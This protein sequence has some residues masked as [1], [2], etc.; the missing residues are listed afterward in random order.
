MELLEADDDEFGRRC[1]LMRDKDGRAMLNE[2]AGQLQ[3]LS[4]HI[5][6]VADGGR[7]ARMRHQIFED[8][9]MPEKHMA[10]AA[11]IVRLR[12]QDCR[13]GR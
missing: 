13:A 9:F 1:V 6:D 7:S 12:Q 3:R 5:A 10:L 2:L 8:S 4:A 11:D